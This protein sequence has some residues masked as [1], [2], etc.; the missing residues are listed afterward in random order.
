MNE[1]GRI[2]NFLNSKYGKTTFKEI[3]R[4]HLSRDSKVSNPAT[5]IL[6]R[7]SKKSKNKR[8]LVMGAIADVAN[9]Y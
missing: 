1:K 7:L 9:N 3:V 4:D 8:Q 2:L 5:D 6:T